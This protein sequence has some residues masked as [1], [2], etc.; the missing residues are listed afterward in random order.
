MYERPSFPACLLC[1]ASDYGLAATG[2]QKRVRRSGGR[3]SLGIHGH[4]SS[5]L[6]K[7]GAEPVWGLTSDRQTR[8]RADASETSS[9]QR[10]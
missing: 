1:L 2:A 8:G 4:L 3:H 10:K 9:Q 7:R 6:P 5:S